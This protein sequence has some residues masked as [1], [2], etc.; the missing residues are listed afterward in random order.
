MCERGLTKVINNAR[1][2]TLLVQLPLPDNL[3]VNKLLDV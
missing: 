2:K 1:V 3:I